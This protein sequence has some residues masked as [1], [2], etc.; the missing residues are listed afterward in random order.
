MH[1]FIQR[2]AVERPACGRESVN[3]RTQPRA[4]AGH[5]QLLIDRCGKGPERGFRAVIGE[6]N[7]CEEQTSGSDFLRE[8]PIETALESDRHR[9]TAGHR[10]RTV[11]R[12][13][14]RTPVFPQHYAT[15]IDRVDDAVILNEA[16]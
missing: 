16:Q 9:G 5:R 14:E 7:A 1:G 3:R 13:S 4:V 11:H 2:G 10:C 12:E 6:P 15:R 8:I